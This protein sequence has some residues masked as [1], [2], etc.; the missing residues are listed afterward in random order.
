M[1]EALSNAELPGI[2]LFVPPLTLVTPVVGIDPRGT[3]KFAMGDPSPSALPKE[4]GAIWDGL[5]MT[6]WPSGTPA[7]GAVPFG[8]TVPAFTFGVPALTFGATPPGT[9]TCTPPLPSP[10]EVPTLP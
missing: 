6:V 3:G 5:T 9:P 8:V 10:S 4:E 2:L 1:P 7:V